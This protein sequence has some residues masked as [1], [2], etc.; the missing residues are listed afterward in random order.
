M[1]QLHSDIENRWQAPGD[2]TDVPLLNSNY[3]TNQASTSTRFLVE[4]DYLNFANLQIGYSISSDLTKKI[5]A[6]SARIFLTGD[7]L[8]ILTKR[9]GFNPTYSLSG[10]TGRYTYEPM[11]TISAGLTI[12]F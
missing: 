10:G 7:N 1:Q 11:T 2:I 8:M 3:Q 5:S 9:D 12:N 6:S 4:A